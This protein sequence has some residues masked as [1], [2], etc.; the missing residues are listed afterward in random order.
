MDLDNAAPLVQLQ[1]VRAEVQS[2]GMLLYVAQASYEPGT[3]PL[4]NWI[5]LRAYQTRD[6]QQSGASLAE[7]PLD[8]F[9]Q[10]VFCL[11][12]RPFCI[13]D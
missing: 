12:L 2:D 9:E 5:P 6:E 7:S 4:S 10:Y 1:T 8:V 13:G 3:S 11:C